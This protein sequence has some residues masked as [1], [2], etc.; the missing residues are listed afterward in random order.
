MQSFIAWAQAKTIWVDIPTL[1][2]TICVW[3]VIF[4]FVS[5]FAHLLMGM[6]S[7]TS[8]TALLNRVHELICEIL[9]TVSGTQ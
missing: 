3:Q 2:L 4:F 6:V 7:I 5:W 9:R 8:I 1:P